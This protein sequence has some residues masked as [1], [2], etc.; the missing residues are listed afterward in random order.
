MPENIEGSLG[1]LNRLNGRRMLSVSI[2]CTVL[3]ACGRNNLGYE[4][5]PVESKLTHNGELKTGDATAQGVEYTGF[6]PSE[7]TNSVVAEVMAQASQPKFSKK[8][9]SVSVSGTGKNIKVFIGWENEESPYQF[10]QGVGQTT[11]FIEAT[12]RKIDFEV[13]VNCLE[14]L[15]QSL[16]VSI[17]SEEGKVISLIRREIRLIET[18]IKPSGGHGLRK[19]KSEQVQV[20]ATEIYPGPSSYYLYRIGEGGSSD[21]IKGMLL[22]TADG[23]QAVQASGY[24]K[25]LGEGTLIG[26]SNDGVLTFKFVSPLDKNRS[27]QT[28]YLVLRPRATSNVVMPPRQSVPETVLIEPSGM[29][30]GSGRSH[31]LNKQIVQDSSRPEVRDFIRKTIAVNGKKVGDFH[32]KTKMYIACQSGDSKTC[33]IDSRGNQKTLSLRRINSLLKAKG[34]PSSFSMVAMIES[35]LDPNAHSSE[36]AMGWWQF[37]YRTGLSM[38]LEINSAK[39]ID[40]RRDLDKST[41]AASKYFYQLLHSWRGDLKLSLASYNRGE[42]GVRSACRKRVK[43]GSCEAQSKKLDH[44]ALQDLMQVSNNDFWQLYRSNVLPRE[45][46]LY[47]MKFLSGNIV[48][49]DPKAYGMPYDPVDLN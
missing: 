9:K 48:A 36:G 34:F 32:L 35:M 27:S 18:F 26:N 16:K 43:D 28:H 17:T 15:C 12:G 39:K 11:K 23:E 46:Q 30:T 5:L 14:S 24:F 47:V 42:F 44:N 38:G 6:G 13:E 33:G 29:R 45:T 7:E 31:P 37:T 19:I 3:A 8:V 40:Q 2:I 20:V 4:K 22:D 49:M 10:V 21:E 25:S 1:T 41:E